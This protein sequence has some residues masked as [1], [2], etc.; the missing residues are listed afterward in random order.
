MCRSFVYNGMSLKTAAA[1]ALLAGVLTVSCAQTATASS[2]RKRIVGG[3]PALVPEA[4][5]APAVSSPRPPRKSDNVVFVQ[6]DYRAATVT[7]VEEPEGYHAYK[8]IRYAEPPVGRFRFQV[9]GYSGYCLWVKC[10]VVT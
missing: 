2:R 7:G 9:S 4:D 3:Y 1:L 8:G 5:G 6:D 10:E